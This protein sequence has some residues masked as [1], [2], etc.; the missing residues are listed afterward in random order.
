MPLKLVPPGTRKGN[1]FYLILGMEGGVQYEVSTRTT[2]KVAAQIRLDALKAQIA[3]A[4]APG[5]RLT[6]A[7]AASLYKAF[8]KPRKVEEARIDKVVKEI[9]RRRIA[10]LRH[11]DLVAAANRMLPG[12]APATLNRAFMRPAA[13]ILHYAAD[14]AYCAW[15]KVKLFEEPP[16]QTRAARPEAMAELIKATAGRRQLLLIWLCLQGTRITQTIRVA[17][18]DVDLDRG[19]FQMYD[20]KAKRWQEFPLH[21]QVLERLRSVPEAERTGLIFPGGDRHNVYRWLRPLARELGV[22]FTPHMARHSLGTDLNA[23]WAGLRT[24]MGTLGHKDPRSSMRYQA[25]ET[26]IIRTASAK[27]P[28]QN[29]LGKRLQVIDNK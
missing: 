13:A 12:R 20:A 21:E 14:N 16:P 15:L 7:Q 8:R 29:I 10:E 5:S 22:T 27:I 18:S 1:K 2:D 6:F 3:G 17:W 4:P 9:G 25:A 19:V 23:Q 28:R 11:A 24:I 26:E